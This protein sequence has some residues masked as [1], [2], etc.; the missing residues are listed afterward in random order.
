LT[1]T[2]NS[3]RGHKWSLKI[4]DRKRRMV[5]APAYAAPQTRRRQAAVVARDPNF[6]QRPHSAGAQ[7]LLSPRVVIQ[8]AENSK[9]RPS[10]IGQE[11]PLNRAKTL[12]QKIQRLIVA[13]SMFT[14]QVQA[15]DKHKKLNLHTAVYRVEAVL[16]VNH[17]DGTDLDY[18]H[19]C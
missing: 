18:A 4:H 17:R 14:S 1:P 11:P 15:A 16:G 2:S 6:I 7:R 3:P 10:A 5:F 12:P 19:P 8:R 9:V 13:V